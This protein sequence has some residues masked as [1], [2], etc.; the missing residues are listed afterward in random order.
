MKSYLSIWGD[1]TSKRYGGVDVSD[2]NDYMGFRGVF[3]ISDGDKYPYNSSFKRRLVS[4]AADFYLK[5]NLTLETNYS[6][7]QHITDGKPNRL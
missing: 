5:E 6:F 1:C 3:Y 7:Y 4:L 2:K